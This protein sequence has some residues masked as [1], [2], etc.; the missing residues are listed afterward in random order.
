MTVSIFD[1]SIDIIN[2]LIALVAEV[3]SV[4]YINHSTNY[5]EAFTMITSQQPDLVVLDLDFHQEDPYKLLK[6]IKTGFAEIIVIILSI[7]VD[8][9]IKLQCRTLGADY[10]FDKYHEFEKIPDIINA[11]AA[12]KIKS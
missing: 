8:E 3:E 9:N 6:E 10:F 2:R 7:H 11:T 1:R 12:N 5:A 4:S